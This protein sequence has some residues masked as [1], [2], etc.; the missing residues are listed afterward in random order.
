MNNLILRLSIYNE[1]VYKNIKMLVF[2]MA[3]TTINEKGI[4]YE[5]L[6]DTMSNFG[7]NVS[8]NEICKWHGLNKYEVLNNYL[9]ND[10]K[11]S[12]EINNCI[13]EQLFSNFDNNLKE[14]YFTSS[15]IDL[16]HENLPVLFDKIRKKD[17]KIALNT[18]Y[19]KEI[20]E[21]II[22][23]LNMNEFI[24]DYISSEEV[25]YGRPYPYM[26]HK[27]MERNNIIN[28][29]NV[30]KFGDTNNDILEGINANC[31]ASIGVLSGADSFSKLKNANHIINSVMDIDE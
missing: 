4:V 26:I 8:R 3:G 12:D 11:V 17:V 16:I 20:Q 25:K 5:T 31:I 14:R 30:I 24:D 27:L 28:S 18:G 15:N 21:S 19:S 13:K 29:Q 9:T 22:K 7:L 23:K 2:D 10:K 1:K 6:Y